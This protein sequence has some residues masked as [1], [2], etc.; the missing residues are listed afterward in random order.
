M[1]QWASGA[2][3]SLRVYNYRL[4]A[5]GSL[6]SNIGTWMQRI[7]QDWLVLTELT[8]RSA[9][10]VGIVTALQFAPQF[11]FLPWTGL[12]ADRFNQRKLMMITQSAMA[13]FAFGLGLLTVTGLVQLWHVYIFAFLLG[14]AAAFDAPARQAFVSEMVGQADLANAVAL[15]SMTFNSARMI[16]PAIAGLAIA[17]IGTGWAFL[18]NGASYLAVLFSLLFLRVHEL[19]PNERARRAVGGFREGLRY[20]WQRPD[21]RVIMV[22]L[23]LIGTFGMNFAIWISTM[24]VKVFHTDAHGYGVLSTMMAVGTVTGAL[25]AAG[26]TE[27]HFRNLPTGTAIF[28]IGCLLAA[29]APGYWFFAAALVIVGVSVLTFLNSS[30]ALVQLTTEPSMRGRVMAIRMAIT[31]GGT[32]LGAPLIGWVTDHYGPRWSLGIG[33]AAGIGATL[34]ALVYVLRHGVPLFAVRPDVVRGDLVEREGP[35]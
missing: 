21:L 31:L 18:A 35:R 3:R 13:I 10:A 26:R 5:T 15:N 8:D 33:V 34:V 4:W 28:A 20:V 17:T 19:V 1:K 9:S 23:F 32:P 27:P 2:F 6:V 25:L 22:M 24:A 12:A 7:A 30:N 11:L 14:S 16:G 29:L